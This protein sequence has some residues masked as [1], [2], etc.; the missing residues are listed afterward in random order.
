MSLR[1]LTDV[2]EVG[3]WAMGGFDDLGLTFSVGQDQS[4]INGARERRTLHHGSQS[5]NSFSGLCREKDRPVYLPHS[6]GTIPKKTYSS[7]MFTAS[8][9]D[10]SQNGCR[11]VLSFSL[12]RLDGDRIA[13]ALQSEIKFWERYVSRNDGALTVQQGLRNLGGVH[14]WPVIH[15]PSIP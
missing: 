15:F 4:Q 7:I 5:D 14:P 9:Q 6:S 3:V 12:S 13:T 11:F 10:L 1:E 8:A 2:K